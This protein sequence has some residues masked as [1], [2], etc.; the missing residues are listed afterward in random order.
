[1]RL[2]APLCSLLLQIKSGECQHCQAQLA[3]D[4]RGS[5]YAGDGPL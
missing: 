3:R 2:G 4:T 5:I 1:M